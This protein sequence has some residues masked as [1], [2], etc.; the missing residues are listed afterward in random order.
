MKT[1]ISALSILLLTASADGSTL[2]PGHVLWDLTAEQDTY[3]VGQQIPS[4]ASLSD[5]LDFT[6]QSSDI[7]TT[8]ATATTVENWT[9]PNTGQTMPGKAILVRR[10]ASHTG[11]GNTAYIFLNGGGDGY[12]HSDPM[13][14]GRLK[15]SAD[16]MIDSS[17]VP[18]STGWRTEGYIKS[19][20]RDPTLKH[21]LGFHTS[22]EL[23]YDYDPVGIMD[24]TY[25]HRTIEIDTPFFG[26]VH[27]VEIIID[28]DDRT[29][30]HW[31]DGSTNGPYLWPEA[32]EGE[33]WQI[34]NQHRFSLPIDV[35]TGSDY[36]QFIWDNIKVEVVPEPASLVLL[37]L[38]FC[39]LLAVGRKK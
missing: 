34:P 28:M 11:D 10:D 16:V 27:H 12:D 36:T 2:A 20:S 7:D 26:Y 23:I 15:I 35:Q 14:T 3:V 8:Q 24:G 32:P 39:G 37:G 6:I 33:E 21:N 31:A 9:D 38:G 30:Q 22:R 25:D 4:Q 19:V 5:P 17:M 1:V 18:Q 29:V 13:V